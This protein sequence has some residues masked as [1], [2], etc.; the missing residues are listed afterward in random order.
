MKVVLYGHE[1]FWTQAIFSKKN[2]GHLLAQTP[3]TNKI[4]CYVF[5]YYS[6][7]MIPL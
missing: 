4:L 1:S 5:D 7:A 3:S 2:E 6:I